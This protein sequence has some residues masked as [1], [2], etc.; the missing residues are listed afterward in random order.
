MNARRYL[1]PLTVLVLIS[2]LMGAC[3]PAAPQAAT[4]APLLEYEAP[5]AEAA[6]PTG[7]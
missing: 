3:A 2:L 5:A 7:G 1:I 4:E 6:A